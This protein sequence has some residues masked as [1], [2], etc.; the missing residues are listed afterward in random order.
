[1]KRGSVQRRV[2][3]IHRQE[4][5][6]AGGGDRLLQQGRTYRARCGQ[7]ATVQ[8]ISNYT[9][10]GF[11]DGRLRWAKTGHLVAEHIEHPWDLVEAI[12]LETGAAP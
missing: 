11:T 1:M 2:Q 9:L 3:T 7:I 10:I 6:F 4:R 12:S 8:A 5:T